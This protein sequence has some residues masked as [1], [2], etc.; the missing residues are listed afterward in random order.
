MVDT[1]TLLLGR[2]A[3]RLR[4]PLAAAS[5]GS[6]AGGSLA[7]RHSRHASEALI[8]A[9]PGKLDEG[10]CQRVFVLHLV[11]HLEKAHIRAHNDVRTDAPL[12]GLSVPG[13]GAER[14]NEAA[15]DPV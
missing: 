12:G 11:I 1:G 3:D 2:V 9:P 15:N 13:N 8:I 10:S 4:M 7:D 5:R 6:Q 14:I